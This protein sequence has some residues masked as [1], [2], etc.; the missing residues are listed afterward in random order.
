MTFLKPIIERLDK[1]SLLIFDCKRSAITGQCNLQSIKSELMFI[2]DSFR[3]NN[4]KTIA[5]RVLSVVKY[6]D[7]FNRLICSNSINSVIGIDGCQTPLKILAD[8]G[9]R[10]NVKSVCIQSCWPSFFHG[11]YKNLPYSD[12]I[13]WGEGFSTLWKNNNCNCTVGG[14]QYEISKS[15]LHDCIVFFLQAP[16]FL[17][18]KQYL[19]LMHNLIVGCARAFPDISILVRSHPEYKLHQKLKDDL[20][21]FPNISFVDEMNL[22]VVFSKARI[23][24]SHF[25]SCIMECLA[26]DCIPIVFDP[27]YRSRY[28]PDIEELKIGYIMDNPEDVISKIRD[29]YVSN[30]NRHEQNRELWFASCGS[31]AT[32]RI[33]D[34]LKV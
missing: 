33:A 2:P 9:R 13:T 3:L 15:G 12:I 6:Y 14:Y 4:A 21:R 27:V 11:G 8:T 29:I 23:G 25:S 28:Y 24:I 18:T 17:S 19:M 34:I 22:S 20:M 5:G 16:L 30:E 26:H 31:E 32:N 10:V 7:L 1:G